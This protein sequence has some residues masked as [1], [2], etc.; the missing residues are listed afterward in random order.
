MADQVN[1]KQDND[2][3][4]IRTGRNDHFKTVFW[5]SCGK[6][7]WWYALLRFV[8]VNCLGVTTVYFIHVSLRD[9][10]MACI[11]TRNAAVNDVPVGSDQTS[12]FDT[13][14]KKGTRYSPCTILQSFNMD[15]GAICNRELFRLALR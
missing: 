4:L 6:I 10:T 2:L 5:R 11:P 8:I 7:F 9:G 15:V 14:S 13:V 12:M 1:V 3:Y